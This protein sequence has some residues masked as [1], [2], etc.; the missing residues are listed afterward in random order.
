MKN[1]QLSDIFF[2]LSRV[3]LKW[4]VSKQ[5]YKFRYG[6]KQKRFQNY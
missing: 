2:I 1:K 6:N 5:I 4:K 3:N